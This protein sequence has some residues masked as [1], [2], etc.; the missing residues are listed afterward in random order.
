MDIVREDHADQP[1]YVWTASTLGGNPVSCAAANAALHI[2]RQPGTYDR[3]DSLGERFRDGL[4]RALR[5]TGHSG[6]ILGDGPLA[7]I[8]FSEHPVFDYRSTLAADRT[9]ARAMMLALFENGI[10]LNP[11][12]TK[13]YLSLA[14]QPADCDEFL[15]RL[16]DVLLA[17]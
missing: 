16:R 17:L 8:A 15:R 7:Q 4:R 13:L 6:Q 2:Y 10:F 9:K 3:L 14:H 1:D 12:G 5:D 11:M